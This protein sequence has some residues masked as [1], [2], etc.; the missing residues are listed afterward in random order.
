MKKILVPTDFSECAKA[1]EKYARFLAK[2][3]GAELRYLHII[4]TPVD[5]SKLTKDQEHLFPEIMKNIANAKESLKSLIKEAED[6]GISASKLLIFNN[7]N[8]KI[9]KY[10][11]DENI[12]L[13]VMGSHGQY[14]FR[15]HILGTNTY[16]MLRRSKVPVVIIRKEIEN[17]KL[18]TLVF[19]TN[20][21]K[22]TGKSFAKI[23]Q[24]AED[25]RLKLHILYVNTPNYFKGTYDILN[26]GKSFLKEFSNYNYDIHIIDAFSVETG[27]IKFLE[28]GE[29][30]GVTLITEGKSDFAQYFSPS[31]TESL[32]SLSEKPVISLR[33]VAK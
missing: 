3:T 20:F 18:E 27:I 19:A 1:S 14:G 32:I 2:K 21:Q 16:S 33:T 30:D 23:E 13:V 9:H 10:A 12:D 28:N 4:N 7:T 15:D 25:L 5:W 22:D 11:E 6:M 26:Q 31:V 24:F 8:D 17:P 29:Y